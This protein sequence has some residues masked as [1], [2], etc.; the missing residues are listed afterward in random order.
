LRTSSLISSMTV[1]FLIVKINKVVG[2]EKLVYCSTKR[3]LWSSK[4]CKIVFGRGSA[5]DPVGGAYDA[6]PNPLVGWGWGYPL[7][8]SYLPRRLWR[9]VLGASSSEPPCSTL[10][11]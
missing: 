8:I 10:P 5:P 3:V 9:L 7:P 4:M 1:M 11:L 2:A 6:P